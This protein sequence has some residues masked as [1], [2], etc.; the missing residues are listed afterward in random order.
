MIEPAKNLCVAL[1]MSLEGVR[2]TAYKDPGGINTIGIGRTKGVVEGESITMAQAESFLK[3]DLAPIFA[4]LDLRAA[5]KTTEIAA[6]CS[7]WFN[8]G[9]AALSRVL[10]GL[11]RIDNPRH[12]RDAK[13]HL[14]PGLLVRRNLEMALLNA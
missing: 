6:Y 10:G 1:L 4:I 2:L 5:L 9:A 8:V 3:E 12:T 13:G 11:D 7:F 14:L